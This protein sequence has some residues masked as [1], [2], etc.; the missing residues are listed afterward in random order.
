MDL[1]LE[2]GEYFLNE[3][4]RKLKKKQEKMAKCVPAYMPACDLGR[5]L[6]I[7]VCVGRA[8]VY[9]GW[10][11]S[12]DLPTSSHPSELLIHRAAERASQKK[13]E[14]LQDFQPP[15]EEKDAAAAASSKKGKAAKAGGGEGKGQ[16]NKSLREL[17]AGLL[18]KKKAKG[19]GQGQGEKRTFVE[20]GGMGGGVGG[21]PSKKHKKGKQRD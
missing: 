17:S 10:I 18:A 13:E 9:F 2:S 16:G 1:Q 3:Q 7:Y 20:G 15:P 19:P 6:Y 12:P 8:L 4:Q 21:E 5:V 11:G 14:R